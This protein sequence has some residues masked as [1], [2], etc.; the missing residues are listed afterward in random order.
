MTGFIGIATTYVF[1]TL[2][3]ANGSMKQLNVMAFSGMVI[4]V[5]LNLI[6]IPRYQAFG[7]AYASLFTQIITAG[8][9]VILAT[10]VFKLKPNY[11][12]LFKLLAFA[13][14][15]VVFAFVSLHF[16]NWFYGYSLM[17]AASV[18]SAFILKLFNLGDLLKL[19]ASR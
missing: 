18:L 19:L 12:F 9:Q 8:S 16:E 14:I 10:V 5:S 2:L 11:M 7:S 3:T 15:T 17:I 13:G 6:L 1:G 4:N